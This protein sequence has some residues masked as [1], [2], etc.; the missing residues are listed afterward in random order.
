MMIHGLVVASKGAYNHD[1]IV[2]LEYGYVMTWL[3]SLKETNEYRDRWL[4]IE[5]AMNK[6]KPK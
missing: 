5:K 1:Q 2:M 4:D 3:I 6:A